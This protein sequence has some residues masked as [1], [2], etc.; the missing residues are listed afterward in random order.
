MLCLSPTL[1]ICLQIDVLSI[2]RNVDLADI[3]H[4]EEGVTQNN[5]E[6]WIRMSQIKIL[7]VILGFENTQSQTAFRKYTR[8]IGF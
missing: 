7:L 2:T 4:T 1:G 3:L 5:F 8:A 6:T